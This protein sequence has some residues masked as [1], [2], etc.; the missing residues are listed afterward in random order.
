MAPAQTNG[1]KSEV[2]LS[3]P[4]LSGNM[5]S[6]AAALG[7][8]LSPP[9]KLLEDCYSRRASLSVSSLPFLEACWPR[10]HL[11]YPDVLL[12]PLLLGVPS[13]KGDWNASGRNAVG[14]TQA[15]L[16]VT[17]SPAAD[18]FSSARDSGPGLYGARNFACSEPT[19]MAEATGQALWHV[20][21]QRALV[22]RA[23]RIQKRLQG[24]LGDHA[25]RHCA[26]QLKGLRGKPA[27]PPD[28]K[29]VVVREAG[30]ELGTMTSVTSDDL[31]SFAR[32]AHA[33]LRE[34]Q[35]AL[36]SDATDSSSDEEPGSLARPV[37]GGC[38]R[39]WLAERAELASRWT[40]LQM[41]VAELESRI[42]QLGS[43]H[44]QIVKTKGG[45]VLAE[46]QPMTDT[47]IQQ[48]LLTETA[49]LSF[50][51]GNL[52]SDLDTEHCSP[53]RLLWN[54]QRQSAQLTQIVNSLMPPLSLSP[55]SSPVSKPMLHPY[56]D[57]R[58]RAHGSDLA[59]VNLLFQ[60]GAQCFGQ[61]RR[62]DSRRKHRFSKADVT[63]ASARTRPLLSYHKPRIFTLGAYQK[64]KGSGSGLSIAAHRPHPVLSLITETPLSVHLQNGLKESSSLLG[65]SETPHP[66]TFSCSHPPLKHGRNGGNS[67]EKL[68][69]SMQDT[70]KRTHCIS[71]KRLY[72]DPVPYDGM[73]VHRKSL[74]DVI[75][76][77]TSQTHHRSTK[78]TVR[79][80]NGESVYN[81]DN[82]VI[83]MSPAA[84]SKVEKLQYKDIM[85][86]SWRLV[87]IVPLV[88]WEY[89]QEEEEKLECLSDEVFAQRHQSCESREK[90]RWCSWDQVSRSRRSRSSTSITHNTDVSETECTPP[91]H[92]D[93]SVCTSGADS[94][95]DQEDC[96]PQLPWDKRVFPLSADEE[97]ALMYDDD[98]EDEALTKVWVEGEDT[99]S[100][101]T[102]SSS[103]KNGC[104][105]TSAGHKR[106]RRHP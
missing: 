54:I 98:E 44:Q 97:E 51:S 106:K 35:A 96:A 49:G 90:L 69:H 29:C 39:R 66:H 37:S 33:T 17:C 76:P 58:K 18:V 70:P 11:P 46:S 92:P 59:N 23:G 55:G 78:F 41:R 50:T 102:D 73:T 84:T 1:T 71:R 68:Q 74:E 52:P 34:V 80:R 62:Q 47:Q 8:D 48:T 65:F 22:A 95:G 7:M 91:P 20:S 10:S 6:G 64:L 30:G 105:G 81:I 93:W 67:E 94:E 56:R 43:L 57:R 53:T 4:L 79:K 42:Q 45:V 63:C 88:K 60:E 2:H 25:S 77:Q 40:W 21:R 86:P 83:S 26:H 5:D 82:V 14:G 61:K 9:M 16:Q 85:T 75:M 32:C 89:D 3:S 72:S 99:S 101:S 12:Q 36:D 100:S 38:E 28:T 13:G 27:F 24:L 104:E 19:R 31:Q 87:D 103:E 15:S